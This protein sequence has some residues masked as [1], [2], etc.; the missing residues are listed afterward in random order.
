MKSDVKLSTTGSNLTKLLGFASTAVAVVSCNQRDDLPWGCA[1]PAGVEQ[2]NLRSTKSIRSSDINLIL[3][4]RNFQYTSGG[5]RRGVDDRNSK[6]YA[7]YTNPPLI[8]SAPSDPSKAIWEIARGKSILELLEMAKDCSEDNWD[9]Y[10]ASQADGEIVSKASRI[11]ASLPVGFPLPDAYI[12]NR[13][14]A[15]LVWQPSAVAALTLSIR[16]SDRAPLSWVKSGTSGS[17]VEVLRGF[18]LSTETRKIIQD[19]HQDAASLRSA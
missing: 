3:L 19:F 12:N 14:E 5:H 10:G 4:K 7:A 15:S 18:N 16:S 2:G 17:S 6:I 11:I 13:G 1:V 9:G 8:P